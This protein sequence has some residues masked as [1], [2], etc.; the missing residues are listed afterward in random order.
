MVVIKTK[1]LLTELHCLNKMRSGNVCLLK[2]LFNLSAEASINVLC[3]LL[4]VRCAI[5]PVKNKLI[6]FS[7]CVTKEFIIWKGHKKQFRILMVMSFVPA[8]NF[9]FE[10]LSMSLHGKRMVK[11]VT[12]VYNA[13]RVA[14]FWISLS[15][16]KNRHLC[17][18]VMG[19]FA[20]PKNRIVTVK[21]EKHLLFEEICSPITT[22]H[23][24]NC[25]NKGTNQSN[26]GLNVST[27]DWQIQL[28]KDSIRVCF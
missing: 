27:S 10:N 1:I 20:L 2:I 15:R 5:F 23:T 7:W 8:G 3:A 17:L 12:N 16:T 25:A 28:T 13:K 24:W 6:G 11:V 9:K 21:L 14:K 4:L 19:P 18:V 22:D 26:Y